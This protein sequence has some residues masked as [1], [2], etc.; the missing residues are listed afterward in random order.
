MSHNNA[1]LLNQLLAA[2]VLFAVA[3]LPVGALY[4]IT[5][6]R[7]LMRDTNM[8]AQSNRERDRQRDEIAE[9]VRRLVNGGGVPVGAAAQADDATPIAVPQEAPLA[10]RVAPQ[11]TARVVS[12]TTD[13]AAP[14]EPRSGE[15]EGI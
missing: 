10:P 8:R 5:L 7:V 12:I 2:F 13:D 6:L 4:I 9:N 11:V 15:K 1:E 3:V 14:A